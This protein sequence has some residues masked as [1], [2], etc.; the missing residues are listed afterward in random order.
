M[1]LNSSI[2]RLSSSRMRTRSTTRVSILRFFS[3]FLLQKNKG[4]FAQPWEVEDFTDLGTTVPKKSY[5]HLGLSPMRPN[6]LWTRP[7]N[8]ATRA[9][10]HG[11]QRDSCG[12]VRRGRGAPVEGTDKA[13]DVVKV[14]GE[15]PATPGPLKRNDPG[16]VKIPQ[17]QFNKTK[18]HTR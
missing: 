8:W 14:Q 3:F 6:E 5:H 2:S 10:A 7:N 13:S 18:Q 1:S 12:S 16:T 4:Y 9:K 11:R 15:D 17:Y